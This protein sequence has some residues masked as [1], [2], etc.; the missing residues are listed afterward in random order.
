MS[1]LVLALALLGGGVDPATREP[2]V[3]ITLERDVL[4]AFER[5][6]EAWESTPNI[7]GDPAAPRGHVVAAE[8]A[9]ARIEELAGF[10]HERSRRCGGFIAH[11]SREDALYAA[12]RAAYSERL[13]RLPPPVPYTIAIGPVAR[14]MAQAVQEI[15]IRNTIISLAAFHTRRHNCPTG[16]DS[17]LWIRDQWQALAAGRPD[18]TVELFSH[19]G[20]PSGWATNQP[21][22]I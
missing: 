9:E 17:A 2:D 14:A 3:W 19:V 5:G 22:V 4:A 1:A 8:M 13:E 12:S 7:L 6:G 16:M 20:A 11:G 21:S 15:N 18:V 10:V